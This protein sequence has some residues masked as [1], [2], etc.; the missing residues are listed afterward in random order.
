MGK[1]SVC[2][3][4][5]SKH[6]IRST[7]RWL[8]LMCTA[9]ILWQQCSCFHVVSSHGCLDLLYVWYRQIWMILKYWTLGILSNCGVSSA[10]MP[11]EPC[12][13][14]Y[15]RA[16]VFTQMWFHSKPK[17]VYPCVCDPKKCKRP[18]MLKILLILKKNKKCI[19]KYQNLL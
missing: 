14:G 16:T 4:W 2:N 12:S 6:E 7:F 8:V 5:D 9:A 3:I 18:A 19:N 17:C 11:L 1:S 10:V 13:H 15:P